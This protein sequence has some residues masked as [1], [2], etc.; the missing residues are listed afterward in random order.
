MSETHSKLNLNIILFTLSRTVLNT[1]YRM[2]YPFLPI[3]AQGLG[4]DVATLA[5]ALSIRSF[6]GVFGP[7]LATIADTHTRKSGILLGLGLFTAGSAVTGLWPQ[8]WGFIIGT[9]LVLLG[10]GVFIPSLNAYLG[11][12]VPYERRGRILAITELSW[13]LAFILG[14]PLVQLMIEANSW[15]TPFFYL[16]IIGVLFFVV[17]MLLLPSHTIAKTESNTIWRNMG[18]VFSTWPALAGLLMGLFFTGA[19]EMINLIFGVWIGDQ[20]G[21]NFAALTVASMVIGFSELGGEIFSTFWLDRFGKRRM[22]LVFLGLNSLCA[23]ALPL[24]GTSLPWALAGL[25]LFYVTFEITII[26][27]LTMMTEILP[28]ARATIMA[29]TVASF[30]LGRMLGD[31]IAP[32]L[33]GLSF[34][35]TSLGAVGLNLLAA[36]FLTQVRVV[37][38][39]SNQGG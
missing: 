9:S 25:G 13:A 28:S 15:V 27:T 39:V 30:S 24:T 8:F 2:V 11:D 16:T 19:N 32:D 5:I 3:F 21:L 36:G 6:L 29:M 33:Y 12:Q 1:S 26:S 18:R 38:P 4:V 31:L 34:W 7:F 35:A 22:I 17:F 37:R 10:N 23:L 14:I 20:F